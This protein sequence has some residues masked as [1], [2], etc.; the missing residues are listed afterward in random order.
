MIYYYFVLDR[1]GL[2]RRFALDRPQVLGRSEHVDIHLRDLRVSRLHAKIVMVDG[3][4]RIED[5]GSSNFTLVNGQ[6]IAGP[7]LLEAGDVVQVGPYQLLVEVQRAWMLDE[8]GWARARMELSRLMRRAKARP[9]LV[10][11]LAL[12]IAAGIAFRTYRKKPRTTASITFLVSE[13]EGRTGGR[14]YAQLRQYVFDAIFTRAN[15]MKV[16]EKFKLFRSKMSLDKNWAIDSMR[17]HIDIGVFRNQF[18]DANDEDATGRS[19]RVY[20]SYD[21]VTPRESV[22]VVRELGRLLQAHEHKIQSRSAAIQL[23]ILQAAVKEIG[24]QIDLV[25]VKINRARVTANNKKASAQARGAARMDIKG[26]DSRLGILRTQ[27]DRQITALTQAR[28]MAQREKNS[29]GL[30]FEIV[31][32]GKAQQPPE[33]TKE[34]K[35]AVVGVLMFLIL[36][37]IVG[38]GIGALDDKLY[39]GEDVER[40]GIPALGHVRRF[41]GD[42]VGS[43]RDRM[44]RDQ[45]QGFL[46][47]PE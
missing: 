30:T 45:K 21:G 14:A 20:I 32:W 3:Q 34:I 25:Q 35:A 39:S 10:S 19:A 38:I 31:D 23:R 46:D 12:L 33:L 43:F 44:Q 28:L 7:T 15:A 4:P 16:I 5:V 8:P 17:D 41:E 37:P 2:V 24:R 36:L 29:L 40:L 47:P 22:L 18:I 11:A 13:G 1:G 26:L 6:R 9:I 42:T 27:F